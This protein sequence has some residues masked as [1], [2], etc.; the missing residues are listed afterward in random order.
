MNERNNVYNSFFLFF[1][2]M[3]LTLF[4]DVND[5][6]FTIIRLLLQ[7]LNVYN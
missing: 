1:Y 5:Q 3:R 6:M 2:G 4:R 7:L